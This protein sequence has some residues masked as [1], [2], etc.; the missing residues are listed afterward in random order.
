MVSVRV[1]CA[2]Q[3][4]LA[5]AVISAA[6]GGGCVFHPPPPLP[7]ELA[8]RRAEEAA[9]KAQVNAGEA[10][11]P[12][13]EEDGDAGPYVEGELAAPGLSIEE[14][15]EYAVSQGDPAG[16]DFTLDEA[17]VDLPPD[18][19]LWAVL[20]TTQGT[21][22]CR[23]FADQAPITVANF[24]GLARGLRPILDPQTRAWVTR[25]V[26]DGTE[27]HRV[28]PGFMIQGGDPSG[29]GRGNPGYVIPDELVPELRH[30][31]PGLLSMAN[32]GPGTGN[33]QFFITLAPT[34]HLDDRHTIFGECTDESI[35]VADAIAATGGPDDRPTTPQRLERVRIERRGA[36]AGAGRS[37]TPPPAEPEKPAR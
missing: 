35:D 32:R 14:M 12:D 1:P 9:R 11:D 6:L 8:A 4:W 31:R 17:L 18:G 25:P 28:I 5:S 24:V 27:F 2:P 19:E 16:G 3:R 15:R 13:G 36:P 30:D 10:M 7:E 34:P 20:E 23:L 26:Y 21:I 29:T 22:E 33:T 37:E